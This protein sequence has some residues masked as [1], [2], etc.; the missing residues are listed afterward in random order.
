MTSATYSSQAVSFVR[1][2][3]KLFRLNLLV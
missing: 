1:V 3:A 2:S